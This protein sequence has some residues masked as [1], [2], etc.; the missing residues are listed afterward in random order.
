[1]KTKRRIYFYKVRALQ[2]HAH[3]NGTISSTTVKLIDL[4]TRLNTAN[5][6][7]SNFSHCDNAIIQTFDDLNLVSVK[8]ISTNTICGQF[9]KIRQRD[10][11][12]VIDDT[13]VNDLALPSDSALY[14]DSHFVYFTSADIL[15]IEFNIHAPRHRSLQEYLK[16][17]ALKFGIPVDEVFIDF[18]ITPNSLDKLQQMG[19]L[20]EFEVTVKAGNL[21]LSGQTR[22]SRVFPNFQGLPANARL[23]FFVKRGRVKK[24]QPTTLGVQ[25][26]DEAQA[27]WR[28][29]AGLLESLRL[30]GES[31]TQPGQKVELD[32]FEDKYV[33]TIEVERTGSGRTLDSSDMFSKIVEYFNNSVVS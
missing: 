27:L 11:P 13:S 29:E 18:L 2:H 5:H 31:R 16:Q 8:E 25:I 22:I 6:S 9:A 19:N 24:G 20:L 28:D 32:F 3:T 33:T 12:R 4:L 7:I 14:E 26:L 1:M 23:K 21:A 30:V 15:A 17:A 10:F